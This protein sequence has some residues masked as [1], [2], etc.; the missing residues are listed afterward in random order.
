M[1]MLDI[2]TNINISLLLYATEQL[3]ERLLE[4]KPYRSNNNKKRYITI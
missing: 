2:L 4:I 1:A 3:L